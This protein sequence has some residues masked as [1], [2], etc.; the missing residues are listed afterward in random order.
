V[1]GSV[2]FLQIGAIDMGVNFR[3]G[4]IGMAE[5]FLHHA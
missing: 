3:G 5:H 4:N 1:K 2:N